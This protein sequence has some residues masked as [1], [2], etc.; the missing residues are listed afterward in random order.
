MSVSPVCGGRCK[1][2]GCGC[3]AKRDEESED[4]FDGS[5]ADSDDGIDE[6]VLSRLHMW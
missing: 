4:D 1:P 6:G 3:R 5:G 2:T